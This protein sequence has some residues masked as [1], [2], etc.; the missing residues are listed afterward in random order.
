MSLPHLVAGERRL[1]FA[2]LVTT[3][4]AQAGIAALTA[5][6]ISTAI[7]GGLTAPVAATLAGGAVLAGAAGLMERWVGEKL[8]QSY[9]LTLRQ[10]L[11][12]AAI[13]AIG[14][15]EEARLVMP[16][17][18]DLAAVRN[19]AARGPAALLT[20]GVA[21]AGGVVL[22][23]AQYPGLAAGL[24]PLLAAT[25]V[26]LLLYRQLGLRIADQR[27]VRAQLTR[28][29]LRRLHVPAAEALPGH[30]RVRRADRRRLD[31]RAERVAGMAIRRARIVGLMDAVALMGGSF[32]ALALL[33]LGRGDERALIAALGLAGFASARLLDVARALHA[34]A[35]GGV[36]LDQIRARL[37][38]QPAPAPA[39]PLP[40]SPPLNDN[41]EDI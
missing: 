30:Q 19:W 2:G 24:L 13:P 22:L 25:G 7:T 16:F 18:G 20:A 12:A 14:R 29:I 5:A 33:S 26:L 23:I 38:A 17:T 6:M 36:A 9:V 28:F 8:A 39:T 4:A 41:D 37:A 21:S 15:V 34:Q 3:G 35:G 11:F 32:A 1:L 40:L 10:R 27:K 31:E